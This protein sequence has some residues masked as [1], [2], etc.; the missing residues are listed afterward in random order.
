MEILG[1]D[2]IFIFVEAT[3]DQNNTS[4]PLIFEDH[5]VL[6]TNGNVQEVLLLAWGQDAHFFPNPDRP[7]QYINGLPPFSYIA[8]GYDQNGNQICETVHWTNDKPYVIYGYGVVDSCCKLII[9]PG[10]RVYFHGGG[11][12]WVYKYGNIEANGT[13][14][15]LIHI[16]EPTRPY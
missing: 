14:L 2:S 11:G 3:L 16:S 1:G 5:I 6:T 4:N 9:D 12:L 7:I 15:S 10:V 8:G 13:V